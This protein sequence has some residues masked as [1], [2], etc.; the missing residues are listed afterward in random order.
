MLF[1]RVYCL[2]ETHG[3]YN[4]GAHGRV[5]TCDVVRVQHLCQLHVVHSCW[6]KLVGA[7]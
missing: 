1:P 5:G 7:L 2:V 3:L 4:D 6:S